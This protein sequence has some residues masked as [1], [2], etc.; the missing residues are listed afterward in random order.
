M[1]SIR[2]CTFCTDSAGIFCITPTEHW[3]REKC[4]DDCFDD[5][6]GLP[7]G[8][9]YYAESQW[10]YLGSVDDGIR[11]LQLVGAKYSEEMHRYINS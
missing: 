9:A 6:D 11:A 10:E 5:I 4:L 3:L 8:F 1:T 2:A 7:S